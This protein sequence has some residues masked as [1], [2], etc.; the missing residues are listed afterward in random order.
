M[1]T[2]T[3]QKESA[4]GD[5]KRPRRSKYTIGLNMFISLRGFPGGGRTMSPPRE[6]LLEMLDNVWII[7]N[8]KYSIGVH[9]F[10]SQ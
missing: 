5:R 1:Y 7:A 9:I 2:L 8:I 10:T 6:G 4:G 3:S